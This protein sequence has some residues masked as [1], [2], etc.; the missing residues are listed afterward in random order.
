VGRSS[1]DWLD[2]PFLVIR[3]ATGINDRV[4]GCAAILF[5]VRGDCTDYSAAVLR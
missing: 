2:E 1:A 4:R 5:Q 3:Y